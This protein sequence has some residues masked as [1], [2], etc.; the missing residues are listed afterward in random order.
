MTER[1]GDGRYRIID[2]PKRIPLGGLAYPITLFMLPITLWLALIVNVLFF[3]I[4][5]AL[6]ILIGGR[7]RWLDPLLCLLAIVIFIAGAVINLALL[8]NGMS[9]IAFQYAQDIRIALTALPLF[10]IVQGQHRT[11]TLRRALEQ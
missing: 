10:F 6:G 1:F 8:D 3:F 7:H 4:P 2:E 5:G 9:E 11:L